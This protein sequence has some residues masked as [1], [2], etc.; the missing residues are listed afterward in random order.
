MRTFDE[1]KAELADRMMAGDWLEA[2]RWYRKQ[3]EDG[4]VIMPETE[5]RPD[6]PPELGRYVSKWDWL[7]ESLPLPEDGDEPSGAQWMYWSARE[8]RDEDK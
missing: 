3:F 5:I 2:M 1:V 6:A 8:A 4:N 7:G